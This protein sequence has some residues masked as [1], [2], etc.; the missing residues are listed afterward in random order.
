MRIPIVAIVA[1]ALGVSALAAL[2]QTVSPQTS[3]TPKAKRLS[4]S[5][6]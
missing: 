6:E 4:T 2:A 1:G 3:D 5:T